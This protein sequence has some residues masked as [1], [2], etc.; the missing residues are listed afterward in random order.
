MDNYPSIREQS[1][2]WYRNNKFMIGVVLVIISFILGFW[3]KVLIIVKFYEPIQLITGLSIYAFS[4]VLLF[5]GMLIVGWQT[6]KMIQ[7]RIHH[8]V[9]TTVKKSYHHAKSLP[10]RGYHYT[11]KL[12]KRFILGE[13][14]DD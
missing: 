6:V 1:I 3:G 2:T 4:F 10:K 7:Y 14:K 11:K 9:K 5:I 12:H 8:H 13:K